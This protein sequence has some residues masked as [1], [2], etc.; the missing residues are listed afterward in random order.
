MDEVSP[1]N[2]AEPRAQ[3][4]GIDVKES[5]RSSSVAWRPSPLAFVPYSAKPATV[6]KPYNLR[7]VVKRSVSVS[8]N[9]FNLL[10]C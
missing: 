9:L 1:S 8:H 6:N 7:V 10:L 2:E 5:P 4:L 3:D